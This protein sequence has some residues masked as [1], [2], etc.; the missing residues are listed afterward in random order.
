MRDVESMALGRAGVCTWTPGHTLVNPANIGDDGFSKLTGIIANYYFVNGL[1]F[2]AIHW[3]H[4]LTKSSGLSVIGCRD[5]GRDYAEHLLGISYGRYIGAHSSMG[6]GFHGAF[7]NSQPSG[8]VFQAG[9][10]WGICT[11]VS[12]NCKLGAVVNNPFLFFNR[13][14]LSL[15]FSFAGG[16][17]Y[18]VYKGLELLAELHKEGLS[19]PGLALGILYSPDLNLRIGTGLN[20]IGPSLCLGITYRPLRRLE[21]SLAMESHPALGL[22]LSHGIRYL[23][24]NSK[25]ANRTD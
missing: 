23:L 6:V 22:R 11:Q 12:A 19:P 20:A 25:N 16:L 4:N 1:Y 15:P 3:E 10:R 24:P 5:G 7:A 8:M 9:M 2:F 17:N 21:W 18:R 14:G 13:N